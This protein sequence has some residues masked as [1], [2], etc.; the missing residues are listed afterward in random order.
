[1][2]DIETSNITATGNWDMTG[3]DFKVPAPTVDTDA[4]TKKY[5]DDN[6]GGMD[7]TISQAPTVIHADNYTD[8]NTTAHASFSQLDYAS[9]GH[10]GFAAALGADDNYVTDA[11]KTIIGNTSGTNTGDQDTTYTGGTNLTLSAGAFNV[12]DAF[13]KNDAADTGVG[14]TLTQD[15]SSADTQFT[16]QVLYNTDDAP[17]AASGFP[18]GTIYVQYTA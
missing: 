9:A 6:V 3:G 4:S 7:W 2:A 8:T 11:E 5:V 16:P 15:N 18:V 1:M 10:T 13:L 12:D 14:L 17:P